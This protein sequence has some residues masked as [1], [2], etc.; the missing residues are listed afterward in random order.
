MKS[1]WIAVALA[2]ALLTGSARAGNSFCTVTKS[3][4]T[5]NGT[6]NT[7]SVQLCHKNTV[8]L[9]KSLDIGLSGAGLTA[10]AGVSGTATVT[11]SG[12]IT[13]DVPP[14]KCV[15]FEYKVQCHTY[16]VTTFFVFTEVHTECWTL[17]A[18]LMCAPARKVR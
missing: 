9:T 14:G 15:Y 11:Q 13:T 3:P 16:E 5:C 17:D 1:I 18:T 12:C 8:S 10:K 2:A 4:G 6:S 7:A